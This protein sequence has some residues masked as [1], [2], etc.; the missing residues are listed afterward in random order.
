MCGFVSGEGDVSFGII[1]L[2]WGA[3]CAGNNEHTMVL[4][5]CQGFGQDYL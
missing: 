1:H 2:G 4:E 3:S 5:D